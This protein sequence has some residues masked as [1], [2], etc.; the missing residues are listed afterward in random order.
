MTIHQQNW[1]EII[2][3]LKDD[4][5]SDIHK[6]YSS[7]EGWCNLTDRTGQQHQIV[8]GDTPEKLKQVIRQ[9]RAINNYVSIHKRPYKFRK[10]LL[11]FDYNQ[12]IRLNR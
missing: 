5:N 7:V 10:N 3:I 8:K 9:I 11:P 6:F 12:S 1:K 4:V 2:K